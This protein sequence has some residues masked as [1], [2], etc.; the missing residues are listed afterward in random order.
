[1]L[2]QFTSSLQNKSSDSD[3]YSSQH[4]FFFN[5][6]KR[7]NFDGHANRLLTDAILI[8]ISALVI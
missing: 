3:N 2:L 4:Y 1:M 5:Y 8:R 6:P 7:D